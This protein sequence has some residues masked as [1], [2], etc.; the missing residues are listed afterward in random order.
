MSTLKIYQEYKEFHRG[1]KFFYDIKNLMYSVRYYM[2]G[3]TPKN[4]FQ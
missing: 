3:K 2:D 4:K 1:T